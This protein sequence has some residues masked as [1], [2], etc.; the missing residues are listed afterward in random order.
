[1]ILKNKQYKDFENVKCI[2]TC[3]DIYCKNA[4]TCLKGELGTWIALP[5]KFVKR[6][7]KKRKDKE[8][9]KGFKNHVERLYLAG[10][11]L[12]CAC[13]GIKYPL[14]FD[15]IYPKSKGGSYDIS[16]GQILCIECNVIKADKI[17]SL[18][19][20]RLIVEYRNKH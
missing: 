11:K 10:H 1:M 17:I 12:E 7:V 20:L 13:C 3:K 5:Q 15:H 9:K 19:E 16:N 2:D 14:T 8:V 4:R 6:I 18:E